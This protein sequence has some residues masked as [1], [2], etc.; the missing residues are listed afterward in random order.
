[1]ARARSGPD[2]LGK[3]TAPHASALAWL[4]GYEYQAEEDEDEAF[5]DLEDDGTTTRQGR[6]VGRAVP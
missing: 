1:L 5:G 2:E 3:G 6:G 4:L